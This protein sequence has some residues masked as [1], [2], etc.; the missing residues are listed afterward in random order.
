MTLNLG[1]QFSP[2][3]RH[4]FTLALGL[5]LH[6]RQELRARSAFRCSEWTHVTPTFSPLQTPLPSR[7]VTC[8]DLFLPYTQ[9][10]SVPGFLLT[11]RFLYGGSN[12]KPLRRAI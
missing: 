12:L 11:V 8:A 5:M 4:V 9:Y 7:S 3:L 2:V 6:Q 10:R 1:L